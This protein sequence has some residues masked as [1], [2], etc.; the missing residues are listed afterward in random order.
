[1]SNILK[2]A[3]KREILKLKAE[4]NKQGNKKAEY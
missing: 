1:M 4:M 2:Q 3:R